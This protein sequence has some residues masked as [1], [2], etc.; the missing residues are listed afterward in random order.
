MAGQ[1]VLDPTR[2]WTAGFKQNV[3][4]SRVNTT[5]LLAR[6]IENAPTKPEVFI[7]ICGVSLYKPSDT[8]VYTEDDKGED[9]DFLSNL[10]IN[11][12]KAATLPA[13]LGVRN[14][15]IRT[16]VVLG[17]EGGMIKSLYFPFFFGLG[18]PVASGT[19]P[20]PWIHV[21]D[22]CSLIMYAVENKKVN[23][24]LNAV[25]PEIIT[26]AQFAKSFGKA[27]R[28]PAL[29]PLPEFVVNMIFQ[30]ERA[31]L[32]TTGPKVAPKRTLE[33]GYKFEFPEIDLACKDCSDLIPH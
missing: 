31:K 3:F 2:S 33:T 26:N 14:I 4:N 18:G 20:L 6:A 22:L 24:V 29:I 21:D 16:G 23:G 12:E 25:A 13:S 27:M 1:N 8:K 32:L 15:K 11:W 9:Y 30:Q 17:R 28:R 5:A 7:T 10:C 19:Q